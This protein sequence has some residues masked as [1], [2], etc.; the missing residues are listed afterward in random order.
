[1]TKKQEGG[2]RL[3]GKSRKSRPGEP[4]ISVVTVVFNGEVAIEETLQSILQQTYSNIE[5]VV[6]DG[7]SSDGT[8]DILRRLDGRI[9]YWSSKPDNGIWD[10]MNKS[11]GLVT[12][13]WLVFMNC[14]DDFP[15]ADTVE[16][17]VSKLKTDTEVLIG[18]CVLLYE[19]GLCV[20][21]PAGVVE[22]LW[23]R[24]ICSQSLWGENGLM[25]KY[26]FDLNEE[27][28]NDHDFLLERYLDGTR[29]QHTDLLLSKVR[30][31]GHSNTSGIRPLVRS[32]KLVKRHKAS[33]ALDLH[34]LARIAVAATNQRIK[35]YAPLFLLDRL[36]RIKILIY[37]KMVKLQ[38]FPSFNDESPSRHIP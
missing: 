15:A 32:W 23:K 27:H 29:I 11:L 20:H 35:A 17:A 30:D 26:P 4:L 31:G 36:L 34:H 21:R 7:A 22:D 2:F 33:I 25:R 5:I 24:M 13:E 6:V 9:D 10:A 16:K 37:G 12:G 38:P 1:M 8:V 18:G 3:T 19:T 14:G 28:N